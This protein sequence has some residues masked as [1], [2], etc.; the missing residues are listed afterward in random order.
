MLARPGNS[1]RIVLAVSLA[2]SVLPGA[3]DAASWS[4]GAGGGAMS[5]YQPVEHSNDFSPVWWSFISVSRGLNRTLWMRS[6]VATFS[7]SGSHSGRDF[8]TPFGAPQATFVAVAMGFRW[9]TVPGGSGIS[10]YIEFMPTA[11]AVHWEQAGAGSF[12]RTVFGFTTGA[13]FHLH[14]NESW[15]LSYGLQLRHSA[16]IRSEWPDGAPQGLGSLTNLAFAVGLSWRSA[17][18]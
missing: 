1:W 14:G 12:T 5:R 16:E 15:S 8:Q 18:D 4:I 10:P 9:Q 11:F 7:Y 13:G 17:T 3:V 2:A 6:E